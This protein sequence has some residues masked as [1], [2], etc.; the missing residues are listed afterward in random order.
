M[1]IPFYRSFPRLV[2]A[3]LVVGLV[4]APR[5]SA[6]FQSGALNPSEIRLVQ[7]LYQDVITSQRLAELA[8]NGGHTSAVRQLAQNA[9][10]PLRREREE[11][12]NLANRKRVPV[13]ANL[14]ASNR[15]AVS[16]LSSAPGRS[17]D[18][19]YVDILL[20]RLP[21]ILESSKATVSTTQDADLKAFLTRIIPRLEARISAAQAVRANL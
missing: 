20:Q 19:T 5:V 7:G 21:V 2:L 8:V 18:R 17:F 1:R 14:T 4:A 12:K 11:I 15:N 3:C 16:R 10:R 13:S 9:I 6:Q